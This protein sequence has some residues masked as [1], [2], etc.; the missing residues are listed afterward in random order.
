MGCHSSLKPFEAGATVFSTVAVFSH[1][2]ADGLGA[3]CSQITIYGSCEK[4]QGC[5]P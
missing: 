4:F 3:R 5:L 1:H 2:E